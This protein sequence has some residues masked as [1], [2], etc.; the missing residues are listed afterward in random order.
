MSRNIGKFKVTTNAP[1]DHCRISS[2][3]P[4]R[5]GEAHSAEPDQTV[6]KKRSSLISKQYLPFLRNNLDTSSVG[7]IVFPDLTPV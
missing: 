3:I 2:K 4:E 6:P 7:Q 1:N 5:N